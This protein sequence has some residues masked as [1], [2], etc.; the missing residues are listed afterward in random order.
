MEKTRSVVARPAVS[1]RIAVAWLSAVL[2]ASAM[3]ITA[4]GAVTLPLPPLYQ[5]R[6]AAVNAEHERALK[7]LREVQARLRAADSAQADAAARRRDASTLFKILATLEKLRRDMKVLDAELADLFETPPPLKLV[8]ITGP[9]TG[10]SRPANAGCGTV[11][12]EHAQNS[13]GLSRRVKDC[14]GR[15]QSS[16]AV[17]VTYAPLSIVP[18]EPFHFEVEARQAAHWSVSP[19]PCPGAGGA[20]MGAGVQLTDAFRADAQARSD[21]N[22]EPGSV[23]MAIRLKPKPPRLSNLGRW[24]FPYVME[25]STNGATVKGSPP[26]QTRF[27]PVESDI[28]DFRL[29]Y[30]KSAVGLDERTHYKLEVDVRLDVFDALAGAPGSLVMHYQALDQSMGFLPAF[31]FPDDTSTTLV[32]VPDLKGMTLPQTKELLGR[33]RLDFN[34]RNVLGNPPNAGLSEKVGGQ[35]PAPGA[36]VKLNAKVNVDLYTK[37]VDLAKVPNLA[38]LTSRIARS[39]LDA[40]RLEADPVVGASAPARAKAGVVYEQ[41]PPAGR[42]VEAGSKVRFT[43]Y[44]NFVEEAVV[45]KVVGLKDG[46]A[47]AQ[48]RGAGLNPVTRIGAK[49]ATREQADTVQS[50]KPA[51]GTRVSPGSS[52][53]L[54]VYSGYVAPITVPDVRRLSWDE[55][56]NRLAGLG[57]TAQRRA[58]GPAANRGQANTV[59][60][61]NP[62]AG[63]NVDR[64]TTVI[65]AVYGAY[66]PTR[67]ELIAGYDCLRVTNSH[68]AWDTA[69]NAPR[70]YCNPGY[71]LDTARKVCVAPRPPTRDELVRGYDCRQVANSHAA[72]DNQANAPRCFCNQGF[73]LDARNNRCVPVQQAR[74][75]NSPGDCEYQ[76]AMIVAFMNNYR[77]NPSNQL[78]KSMADHTAAQAR[79][80]GCDR[81][82][83]DQ[84]LGSGGRGTTRPP[85]SS[86]CPPGMIPGTKP[87]SW[88]QEEACVP[89]GR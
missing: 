23:R 82:R 10:S 50:Q 13:A 85:S 46:P 79:R 29:P 45:P 51:A 53:E 61:Q 9:K 76:F 36:R 49:P 39:K 56:R 17:A 89:A 42:Q 43:V 6:L 58:A 62:A 78:Q 72:W 44:S 40:V 52:V 21:L 68:A 20:R 59:G 11:E 19:P 12:I 37:Y 1:R 47:E 48:L 18:G 55:A 66:T 74:P 34:H 32:A 31:V 83:I 41:S 33:M 86:P 27:V 2:C 25:V 16:A 15:L 14:E 8:R 26:A 57:L 88:G 71:V 35:E 4:A 22:C 7:E 80:M 24:E 67:D 28:T 69:V 3:A 63:A 64:G 54:V 30:R 5:E 60:D 81:A 65:V 73:T 38:G 75:A 84:A 87:G 77:A 70:C